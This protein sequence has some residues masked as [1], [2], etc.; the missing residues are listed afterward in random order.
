MKLMEKAGPRTREGV[1][2]WLDEIELKGER[3]GQVKL[4]LR[5]LAT[6]FGEVPAEVTARVEAADERTLARWAMRVLTTA[7]PEDVVSD[8]RRGT[9]QRPR[10]SRKPA[11]SKRGPRARRAS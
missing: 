2:T 9:G 7:T 5:M 11:A 6:R 4:L 3:K 1:V 10:S 8:S